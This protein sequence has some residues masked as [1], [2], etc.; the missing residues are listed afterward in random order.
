[1]KLPDAGDTDRAAHLETDN[2][3]SVLIKEKIIHRRLNEHGC[4][5][6]R[7]ADLSFR[8]PDYR[9]FAACSQAVLECNQDLQ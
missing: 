6:L 7:A 3:C 4:P 1:M 8:Q 9:V 5:L 2:I